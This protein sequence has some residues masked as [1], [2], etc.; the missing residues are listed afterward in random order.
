[1]LKIQYDSLFAGYTCNG[2]SAWEFIIREALNK[3]TSTV[4]Q[5]CCRLNR[6]T[7]KAKILKRINKTLE[8]SD[9]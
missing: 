9:N 8:K 1:M 4:I 2:I 5:A 7:F 6:P 3:N